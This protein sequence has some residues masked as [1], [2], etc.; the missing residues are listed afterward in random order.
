MWEGPLEGRLVARA[1]AEA[2]LVVAVACAER[3]GSQL[4][5]RVLVAVAWAQPPVVAQEARPAGGAPTLLQ[6]R[7]VHAVTEALVA[8]GGGRPR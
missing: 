1:V 2:S 6:P 7:V 5:A 3:V 8:G 4:G